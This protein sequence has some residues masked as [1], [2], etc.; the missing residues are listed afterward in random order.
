MLADDILQR[1]W[2]RDDSWGG[3]F[4]CG[5][6][7]LMGVKIGKGKPRRVG[8]GLLKYYFNA[9]VDYKDFLSR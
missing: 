9:V 8:P 3:G 4:F 5:V 2:G 7:E 6:G 1:F